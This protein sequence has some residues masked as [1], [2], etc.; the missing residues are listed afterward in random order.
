LIQLHI[1]TLQQL[2]RLGDI[3]G[4]PSRLIAQERFDLACHSLQ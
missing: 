3:A 1:A 2:R 4:N